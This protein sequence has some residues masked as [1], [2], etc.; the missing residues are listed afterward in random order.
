MA[1]FVFA[2]CGPR[3]DGNVNEPPS[4]PCSSYLSPKCS[5]RSHPAKGGGSVLARKLIAVGELIGMWSGRLISFDELTRL[6][7]ALRRHTVQVEENLYLASFRGD[8]PA[9][10]INHSCRPNAG[11][12]GQIAVVALRDICAGEEVTIDY[13]MCDG[14]AYDEFE[15]ACGAPGCR[16]R[17]TGD[18]WLNPELWARYAGHF[19]PYL[20][21]RIDFLR[22]Q[23]ARRKHAIGPHLYATNGR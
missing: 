19:S 5:V 9:D 20:Q 13:A 16:G 18:D 22:Q 11:L 8:E 12:G 2:L 1:V 21:R 10:F 7:E 14:T 6:P 23:S 4:Y 15:C 17:V 3:R